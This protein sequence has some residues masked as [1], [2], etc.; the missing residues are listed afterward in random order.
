MAL[1]VQTM[2]SLDYIDRVLSVAEFA[3]LAGLSVPT[4]RRLIK[5][6][7]GP[8]LIRLSPRRVG[9]R[10]SDGNGWLESRASTVS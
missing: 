10:V 6:N 7:C 2:Q 4:L 5:A 3:A 9:I 1:D 8:R